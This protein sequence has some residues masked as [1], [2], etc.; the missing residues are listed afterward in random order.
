MEKYKEKGT[1]ISPKINGTS[2]KAEAFPRRDDPSAPPLELED[3]PF[4]PPDFFG[5]ID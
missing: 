1:E 3:A 5:A 4:E 2:A